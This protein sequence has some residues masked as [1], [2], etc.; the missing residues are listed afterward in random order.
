MPGPQLP[1][2]AWRRLL[3]EASSLE[4][5]LVVLS[6]SLAAGMPT[7]FYALATGALRSRNAH[8]VVDTSR[9]A[10]VKCAGTGVFLIKASL[11]EL[12]TLAGVADVEVPQAP[13]LATQVV[14]RGACD[15]LVVS[16]GAGGALWTTRT[17]QHRLAAPV[18]PVCSTVGAG[19]AMVG[20]IVLSLARGAPLSE[21][22]CQGVAA[23]S[24]TVMRSGTALCRREDVG[25]L[26]AQV[27]GV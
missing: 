20:G 3:D 10:L 16:L 4:P 15:V 24:A 22:M 12:A 6:G 21:A 1:E 11:H 13:A 2:F 8:V 25:E 14:T 5:E 26:R 9:D 18:V 27:R 17:E 7:A 19:D 23:G